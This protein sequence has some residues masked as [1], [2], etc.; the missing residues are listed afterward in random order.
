MSE[1]TQECSLFPYIS[2]NKYK[3]MQFKKKKDNKDVRLKLKNAPII[4]WM[5]DICNF[6]KLKT[7]QIKPIKNKKI[8]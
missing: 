2:S 6:T 5:T 1:I 7:V 8:P 4:L 3:P